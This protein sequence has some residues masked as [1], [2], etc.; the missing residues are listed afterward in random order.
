LRARY[1]NEDLPETDQIAR[2]RLNE[3][4]MPLYQILMFVAPGREKEFKETVTHIEK[5]REEEEGFSLEAE[6]VEEILIHTK[7]EETNTFLTTDIA[8]RLNQDRPEKGKLSDRLVSI[9][10]AR[11][12]FQKARL[13]NGRRGFLS[14]PELLKRLALQYSLDTGRFEELP[15]GYDA[16]DT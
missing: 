14:N 4:T 16:Y 15:D 10:I 12:G 6:I 13:T 11:L 2:R 8:E 3:I 7:Q 5:K 9:R 1:L